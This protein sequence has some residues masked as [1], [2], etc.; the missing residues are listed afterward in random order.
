M[1]EAAPSRQWLAIALGVVFA[2][3]LTRLW[4][5]EGRWFVIAILAI[6]LISVSMMFAGRLSETLLIVLLFAIPLAGFTKWLI[7]D[8]YP[9]FIKNAAPTG[10]ALSI[11][12]IDFIVAGLYITWAFRVFV[13]REGLREG[14][15]KDLRQARP[16]GWEAADGWVA[17]LVAAT[18]FSLW[19]AEDLALGIG[20][21]EHVVKH[22]L[23]YVYVSRHFKREHLPWFL[24][25]IALAIL[26]Q[27]S[28][29]IIQN[30]FGL[31]RGL[32]FDKGA[33]GELLNYQYTV[34]GIEDLDRATGTTY[35]SHAFGLYV[36]ML[37][38][39][40]F[41]FLYMR[42][43]AWPLRLSCLLLLA[44][45]LVTVVL[46]YSRSAW[47][48]CPIALAVCAAG[49]LAWRDKYVRPSLLAAVAASVLAMPWLL[50]R[51]FERFQTAPKDLLS[52]RFEQYP[53]AW[54]IWQES[55]LFGN[56]AGNYMRG[57]Y[58]HNMDWAYDYPVHNVLLYIAADTGLVGLVA[59]IGLAVVV[60][61]S[62]WR[63]LRG[64]QHELARRVA[65][66]SL[67]AFVAYLFD[68]ISDPLFREPVVYM[69]FWVL[70]AIAVASK[71]EQARDST[72]QAIGTAVAAT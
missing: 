25:A 23:I 28:V 17:L 19:G 65:L 41:V 8:S 57:M 67:A 46:S 43:L 42:K 21:L 24:A 38:P 55:F 62:F 6:A 37:V 69:M 53:V 12:L 60:I 7:P 31:L 22:A 54:S 64:Q 51:V 71:R 45:G 15:R 11:G 35:D 3:G 32:I 48:A 47:L 59:Y 68:G 52:A 40:A 5:L 34:P 61:R 72:P 33:G 2:F 26:M 10:G 1:T 9:E 4:V 20:A 27:A 70:V 49:L 50:G 63:L 16:V 66:A 44:F 56:G 30:R 58:S 13:L 36:A 18:F 39:Y 14:L 29:G